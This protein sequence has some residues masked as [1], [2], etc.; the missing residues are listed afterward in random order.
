MS[1]AVRGKTAN[2][3]FIRRRDGTLVYSS[4]TYTRPV[5]IPVPSS[6]YASS[7]GTHS[8]PTKEM[9]MRDLDK[10]EDLLD[11]AD[12]GY[13]PVHIGDTFKDGRYRIVR[14]LGWGHFSTVWL[15]KDTTS[16]RHVAIKVVKSA[17]TYLTAAR[18]EVGILRFINSV[19]KDPGHENIVQFLDSFDHKAEKGAGP[20][21]VHVCMVFE[22]LGA[23]LLTLIKA[24]RKGV[25]EHLV[26]QIANQVLAGLAFLHERCGIIHTDLKPE[27]IMISLGGKHDIEAIVQAELATS[28]RSLS[29]MV[30]IPPGCVR[31]GVATPRYGADLA[32]TKQVW[33][34]GSQPLPTVTSLPRSRPGQPNALVRK[35]STLAISTIPK[36]EPDS[37]SSSS[38]SSSSTLAELSTAPTSFMSTGKGITFGST[39]SQKCLPAVNKVSPVT[40]VCQSD[41]SGAT[42]TA[43]SEMS[44]QGLPE[45]SPLVGE[46]QVTGI[47]NEVVGFAKAH[48]AVVKPCTPPCKGPSL[49]S[50]TAPK[51]ETP[52]TRS[53]SKISPKIE[54]DTIEVKIGDLGNASYCWKHFTENIQTRQYRC[55]EVILGAE[56]D[57]TADVWSVGCIFFELLTSDVLF[58]PAERPGIWSRDDDHICQMIELL[59]PM[60]PKFALSGD[61]SK[62]IFRSD[63]VTLRNVA[64]SKMSHWPL[65]DVLVQKYRYEREHAERLAEFLLPFL[66]L[67]PKLRIS[68]QDAQHLEW[69]KT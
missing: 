10:E 41:G 33:I 59:G 64:S 7:C 62:E 66:R 18:D 8:V 23:S 19:Y 13:L 26:R 36:P 11:Y 65:L 56:W 39:R 32:G 43:S 60:D 55:P 54:K 67:E 42:M 46:A 58:D 35:L 57:A 28:P 37:A 6:S 69:L 22:P 25:P 53:K 1:L 30:G 48:D 12:G 16:N 52:L 14:K 29:R 21:P 24:H 2:L 47:S 4:G 45:R 9:D 38:A 15:A 5:P 68:A 44:A 31:G 61:Y 34:F 63:G 51:L 27:N 49:L 17:K 3:P 20:L 50:Q 40:I